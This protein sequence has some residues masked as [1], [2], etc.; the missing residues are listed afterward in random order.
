M[1][2][3]LYS[4]GE[5]QYRLS[6]N[7]D[8]YEVDTADLPCTVEVH[9]FSSHRDAGFFLEGLRAAGLPDPELETDGPAEIGGKRFGVVLVRPMAPEG[10]SEFHH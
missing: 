8:F 1:S 6:E 3:K 9:T 2:M 10:Y 4:N 5:G 7:A